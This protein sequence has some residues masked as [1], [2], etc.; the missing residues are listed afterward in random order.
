MTSRVQLAAMLEYERAKTAFATN[1]YSGPMNPTIRSGASYLPPPA[2]PGLRAPLAA[3]TAEKT[4]AGAPTRGG[5]MMA[6]D[7]PPLRAPSLKAPVEKTSDALPDYVTYSPGDFK[8]A[9]LVGK[10][11]SSAGQ[12]EGID[13][14][15]KGSL[16]EDYKKTADLLDSDYAAGTADPVDSKNY[17]RGKEKTS[18]DSPFQAA[19]TAKTIGTFK[20]GKLPAGPSISDIAKPKGAG[21]GTGIA[22]SFKGTIGGAAPVSLSSSPG[23]LK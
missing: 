23:S 8:P 4:A 16:P 12:N 18:S 22:G 20:P 1:A 21:F 17:L 7:I 19:Q 14:N 13:E 5:F 11:K 2:A 9:K 10:E 15:A 3:K 6:S